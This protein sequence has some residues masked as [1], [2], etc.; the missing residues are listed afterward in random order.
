MPAPRFAHFRFMIFSDNDD[1]EGIPT[2]YWHLVTTAARATAPAL[3]KKGKR[4]SKRTPNHLTLGKTI[5]YDLVVNIL[6]S[7]QRRNYSK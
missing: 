5:I 7:I 2:T 3:I 4:I 1:D 6:M